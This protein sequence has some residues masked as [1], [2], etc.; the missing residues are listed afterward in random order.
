MEAIDLTNP[1]EKAA[2]YRLLDYENIVYVVVDV[3]SCPID[4]HSS[5]ENTI[6]EWSH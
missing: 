5:G 2:L 3:G 6:Y 4:T 1:T